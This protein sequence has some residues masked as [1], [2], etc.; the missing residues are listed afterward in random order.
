VRPMIIAS[1]VVTASLSASLVLAQAP[2]TELTAL[3]QFLKLPASTSLNVSAA[4]ALPG[5]TPLKL[6]IATGLD[7]GVRQNFTSWIDEWNRKDGKKHGN[8]VLASDVADAD[9]ILARYVEREKAQTATDTTAGSAVVVDPKTQKVGTAPYAR[10]Y[11]YTEV[12][13]LAYVIARKAPSEL[14]IVW[15]YTGM[16][17]VEEQKNSGRQLWDDFKTMMKSRSKK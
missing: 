14:E 15:R 7:L 5:A 6:F 11:S 1:S 2:E 16:T 13:V 10:E 17:S 12:P 3:R 4:T 9:V 8:V